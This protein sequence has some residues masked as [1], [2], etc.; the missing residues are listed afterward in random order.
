MLY[1]KQLYYY[2]D[3]WPL[4]TAQFDYAL[5]RHCISYVYL[6]TDIKCKIVNIEIIILH[7]MGGTRVIIINLL[8]KAKTYILVLC[9][10][11]FNITDTDH[12]VSKY[13]FDVL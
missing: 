5:R 13:S 10:L 6:D 7:V 2:G 9:K 8:D 4:A 11:V 12:R 3:L 1:T